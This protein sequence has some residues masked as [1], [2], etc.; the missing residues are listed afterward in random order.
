MTR[1]GFAEETERLVPTIE[2][3]RA[4]GLQAPEIAARLGHTVTAL[5]SRMRRSGHLELARMFDRA[6]SAARH[7]TCSCGATVRRG[8]TRCLPCYVLDRTSRLTSMERILARIE[9]RESGCWE[10]QGARSASGYGWIKLSNPR[11]YVVVHRLAW[12]EVH[13]PIPDG[14]MILHSCDNP[15][16]VN[17]D[18]LSLGTHADNMLDRQVRGRHANARKTECPHG[19]PYDEE[20]TIRNKKGHRTC[21]ACTTSRRA[22][23]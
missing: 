8:G 22:R 2:A 3:L 14:L 23:K 17:P 11:R 5:R 1:S 10:W 4:E 18:H 9:V 13:G 21:R 20:N 16:C 7:G 6:A 15:P 12:S 19:H